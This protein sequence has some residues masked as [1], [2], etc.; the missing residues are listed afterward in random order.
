MD[1]ALI[2]FIFSLWNINEIENF[3]LQLNLRGHMTGP[4]TLFSF[5][6]NNLFR[7]VICK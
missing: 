4:D 6:E 7:H 5:L 3:I 1:Y 2:S